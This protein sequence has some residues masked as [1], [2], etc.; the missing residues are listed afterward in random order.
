MILP[1]EQSF[2]YSGETIG[3][4][5]DLTVSVSAVTEAQSCCNSEKEKNKNTHDRSISSFDKIPYLSNISFF[6]KKRVGFCLPGRCNS[7]LNGCG[8]WDTN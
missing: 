1:F 6:F 2:N 3:P 5:I 7:T 8:V 4:L